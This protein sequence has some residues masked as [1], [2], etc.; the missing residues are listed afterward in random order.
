MCQECKT[1]FDEVM[2]LNH[3]TAAVCVSLFYFVIPEVFNRESRFCIFKICR[4]R[5]GWAVPT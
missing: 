3:D 2:S 4:G 1:F 5:V